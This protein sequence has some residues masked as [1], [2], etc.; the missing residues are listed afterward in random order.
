MVFQGTVFGPPLWNT[1][2]EDAAEAIHELLYSEVVYADDLNAY[3]EFPGITPNYKTRASLKLCQQ[4]LH[5]WGKANQ[6]VFDSKKESFH[7]LSKSEAAGAEFKLLGLVLDVSITMRSAVEEVVLE[8][9]WKLKMLLRTKRFYTDGELILLSKDTY[10]HMWSI[11]LQLSTMP[12]A[13]FCRSWI[14]CRHA[15]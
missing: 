14:A 3:R 13:R 10:W 4:E 5:A 6:V 12:P 7:I 8:A 2:F 1:F 11:A 9:G 15:S